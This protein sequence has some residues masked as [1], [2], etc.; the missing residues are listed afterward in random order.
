MVE[1]RCNSPSHRRFARRALALAALVLSCLATS[2]ARAAGGGCIDGVVPNTLGFPSLGGLGEFEVQ[3]T[4]GC[5]WAAQTADAWIVLDPDSTSGFAGELLSF[6]VQPMPEGL[7]TRTGTVNVSGIPFTVVQT[8]LGPTNT[9]ALQLFGDVTFNSRD[10][11]RQY[12]SVSAGTEFTLAVTDNPG[13]TTPDVGRVVGFGHSQFNQCVMPGQNGGFAKVSAGKVHSMALTNGNGLGTEGMVVCWGDAS[14]GK[15][16]VPANLGTC[17]EISAGSTFSMALTTAGT[18]RCWG[19]NTFGQCNV[20]GTNGVPPFPPGFILAIAAGESHG[21]ALISQ[22]ADLP[23]NA[24]VHVW[25]SD[26]FGQITREP[27]NLTGVVQIAAGANHCVALKASGEVVC[28][29]LN[30]NGQ[31]DTPVGL[32]ARQIDASANYT[33][34][35]S[36]PTTIR[37][38]G[39][40]PPGFSPS[41]LAFL[42]SV[43]IR[44]ARAGADHVAVLAE[45]TRTLVL[46]G[47][48]EYFQCNGEV[49]IDRIAGITCGRFS[50][51]A[52][53][54]IGRFELFCTAQGAATY[55]VC[56]IPLQLER[57]HMIALG[58][59]HAVAI[60]RNTRRVVVWGDN[61]EDQCEL[62]TETEPAYLVAAGEAHSATIANG[63]SATFR[64]WGR[65]AYNQCDVPP[66]GGHPVKLACGRNHTL[67]IVHDQKGRASVR[68]WGSW[69]GVGQSTQTVSIQPSLVN[70]PIGGSGQPV[71][72][73]GGNLHS[74]ALLLD[75]TVVS[76]G[77]PGSGQLPTPSDVGNCRTISAGGLHS[78]AV[79]N[80]DRVGAWGNN[81]VNQVSGPETLAQVPAVAAGD[82]RT[83]VYVD[84]ALPLPNDINSD[85]CANGTDLGILLAFWGTD[86]S[87]PDTDPPQSA[88]L[89]GDGIVNGADLGLLLED[90]YAN[91]DCGG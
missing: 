68:G 28:W 55:G 69:G 79:K 42:G 21:M 56:S 72:I 65:N 45:V 44:V 67:A 23:V 17:R 78:V 11:S 71:E 59:G 30:A 62:P 22:A 5:G 70:Q 4:A 66:L 48:N 25:G 89:N 61:A 82:N 16:A 58:Q 2:T 40:A 12:S 52:W 83:L 86:G 1:V 41:Q 27:A 88:D 35:I 53:N 34:A 91:I 81:D 38:W 39:A 32:V 31:C 63:S 54:D 7:K 6:S 51:A 84:T 33:L 77:I 8:Q 76:W 75:G 24:V 9:E 60:E 15:C 90:W 14:G 87:I 18:V 50:F 26:E 80:N 13:G 74:M 19:L 73:S 29:G 3:G 43:G 46:S 37:T 64:C 85:G 57:V 10:L 20:P 49:L 36:D 47:K